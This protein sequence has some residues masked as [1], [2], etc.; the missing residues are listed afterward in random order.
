MGF[1]H[2]NKSFASTVAGICLGVALSLGTGP[3][4]AAQE[5]LSEGG[6]LEVVGQY[7]RPDLAGGCS[8]ATVSLITRKDYIYQAAGG[9]ADERTV[10]YND[11]DSNNIESEVRAQCL[12]GFILRVLLPGEE[13]PW[14]VFH[15]DAD[16]P[17]SGQ[18]TFFDETEEGETAV[19][20]RS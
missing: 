17:N 19:A 2:P 6:R 9:A 5:A 4:T 18:W 12:Q 8:S 14:K 7:Y 3:W 15:G 20:E 16:V 13:Y 11:S 10:Y 1:L